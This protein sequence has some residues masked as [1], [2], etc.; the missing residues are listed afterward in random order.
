MN[1]ER[2]NVKIDREDRLKKDGVIRTKCE[3]IGG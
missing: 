3:K 1:Y 2:C